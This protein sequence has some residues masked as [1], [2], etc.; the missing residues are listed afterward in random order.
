MDVHRSY[1]KANLRRTGVKGKKD[2]D[3]VRK[4]S[5]MTRNLL[6]LG[7]WL[8]ESG[9]THIGVESTGVFWKPVFNV[10]GSDFKIILVSCQ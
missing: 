4:F 3:E 7:D 2:L 9:C 1:I 8:K 10:L 5:T 6:A